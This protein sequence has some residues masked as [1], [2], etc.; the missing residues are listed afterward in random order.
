M[1]MTIPFVL[2]LNADRVI[3]TTTM[4]GDVSGTREVRAAADASLRNEVA[5]WARDMTRGYDH[6][7]VETT[8]HSVVVSRSTQVHNLAAYQDVQAVAYDIVRR[9]FSL[10]T[11]YRW[12]EK[13]G[14]EFLSNVREEAAAPVTTFEY[15]LIMPGELQSA[16]PPAQIDGRRAS[17]TLTADQEEYVLSATATSLRWDII[18]LLVYVFGYVAYRLTA[19]LVRRAK[20]RPR[21]I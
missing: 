12:E 19:F 16:S 14:I 15:R 7:G 6:D 4:Y 10:V 20:L 11:E 3:I 18:I 2:L 9:P 8:A 21:K 17:W 13:I 1:L 5:K